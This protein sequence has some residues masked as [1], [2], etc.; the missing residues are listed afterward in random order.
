MIRRGLALIGVLLVV[1]H[2]W[3]FAGQILAGELADAAVILR[4]LAAA[5]LIA[6]LRQLHRSGSS[7]FFSRRGIALWLLAALLHGP[8]MAQAG[9][10]AAPAAPNAVS[11][12][13]Q[14]T[15]SLASAGLVL[16]FVLALT[17]R[18]RQRRLALRRGFDALASMGAHSLAAHPVFAPRPPPN[19]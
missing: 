10:V 3:L 18:R 13:A 12:L 9:E 4:W 15:I 7:V 11:V 5:G 16:L 19:S 2:G 8:A 1:F 14:V 17:A 6:G